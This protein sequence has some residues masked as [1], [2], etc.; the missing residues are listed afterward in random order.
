MDIRTTRAC[1]K[2]IEVYGDVHQ[3]TKALEEMSELSKELCK[4]LCD[5]HES[6]DIGVF[7]GVPAEI[8]DHIAEEMADVMIMVT[9]LEMI[10]NNTGS[11]RKWIDIKTKRLAESIREK[12]YDF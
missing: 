5:C 3:V 7:P 8:Y 6:R 12:G 2:A 9:Q 11:I 10:F 4:V 1:R